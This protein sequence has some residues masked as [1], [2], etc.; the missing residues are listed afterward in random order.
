MTPTFTNDWFD[1][2]KGPWA[3][4]LARLLPRK[5]LEIGSYE[6][7]SACFM[8]NQLASRF[9][10]ELHCIDT[11]EGGV[12]HRLDGTDMSRVEHRFRSNLQLAMQATAEQ[13]HAVQLAVHKNRSDLALAALLAQGHAGTFDFAYIDG[14]HQAPD[15]LSDAVLAFKLVRVGG[16][17]VFDDYLW[18]ENDLPGGR[19]LLRCPKPAIDAFVNCYFRKVEVLRGPLYQLYVQKTAD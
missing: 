13:P 12:E 5:L 17:M 9:P 1:V 11:W 19:D 8:V 7:A 3:D 14:S 15:V 10:I 16:V 2:V 18:A 4:L 6:G